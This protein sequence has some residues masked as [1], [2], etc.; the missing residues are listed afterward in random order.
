MPLAQK[1]I[2]VLHHR[3]K[4]ASR[5]GLKVEWAEV[6]GVV[7]TACR[8]SGGGVDGTIG[9]RKGLLQQRRIARLG[10][11]FLGNQF[12][13]V[14]TEVV[15][16]LNGKFN[17]GVGTAFDGAAWFGDDHGGETVGNDFNGEGAADAILKAVGIADGEASLNRFGGGEGKERNV[18]FEQG[19]GCAKGISSSF[20]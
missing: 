18:G 16:G 20:S 13:A 3:I 2:I 7:A 14:E 15:G 19:A 10:V 17:V 6:P 9:P 1:I 5:A 12:E 4:D 11:E 8:V